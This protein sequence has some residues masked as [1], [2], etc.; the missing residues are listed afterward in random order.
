MSQTVRNN[1]D[2]L[3]RYVFLVGLPLLGFFLFIAGKVKIG[4]FNVKGV[5]VRIVGIV[6][7]LAAVYLYLFV[8]LRYSGR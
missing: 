2:M 5:V 6:F 1:L 3:S 4:S 7:L 8:H